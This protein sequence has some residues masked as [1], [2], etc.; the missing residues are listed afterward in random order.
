MNIKLLNR[1][2]CQ[3]WMVNAPLSKGGVARISKFVLVLE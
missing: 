3:S 2:H 1:A